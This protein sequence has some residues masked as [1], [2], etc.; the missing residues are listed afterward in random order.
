MANSSQ[1]AYGT[2]LW[3]LVAEHAAARGRRASVAD[4][5]AVAVTAARV[6]GAGLTM[7][8]RADSGRVICV[9]D[10]VSAEMEELQLTFGEGPCM[11]AYAS[12]GPVLSHDLRGPQ[13]SQRWPAFAP[14]ASR[15]GAA[16]VFAFPLQLGTVRLGVMDLYR[17]EARS[18]ETG[19]LQDALV[20]ADT[21]TLLLVGRDAPASDDELAAVAGEGLLSEREGYR[22]EI[23]QATGMI[24]VQADVAIADAFAR[25]R[26]HAYAEDRSLTDVARDVVAR[27]LRFAPDPAVGS[28]GG[29][30][31]DGGER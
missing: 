23:D 20:L 15:I 4:A 9:T 14:A 28:G 8:T 30:S 18:L 3:A 31:G 7:R 5:C 22:A 13:A 11:D 1:D 19:E 10:R 17:S 24:S 12:R 2:R 29:G 26:A 27:R 16:A 6:S 21:A 25:L